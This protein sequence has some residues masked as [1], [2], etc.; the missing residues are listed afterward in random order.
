MN[1]RHGYVVNTVRV[2]LGLLMLF[3]GVT[4]LLAGPE[5]EGVPENMA[6]PTRVLWDTGITHMV[7]VTEAVAGLML[8]V[9]FL[10]WLAVI[11]LAPDAVGILIVNAR[12]TPQFLP[13]AL[14]VVLFEAYLGWAYW[15]RYR[16]LFQRKA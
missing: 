15:D 7:K 13:L 4:G 12:M 5:P 10:P 11:F 9:G 2:L 1:L 16:V 3:A 6:E 14:L 8:V